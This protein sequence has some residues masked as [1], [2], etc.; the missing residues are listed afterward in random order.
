MKKRA[1]PAVLISA[2]ALLI[3][4]TAYANP[5]SGDDVRQFQTVEEMSEA[6]GLSGTVRTAGYAEAGDGGAMTYTVAAAQPQGAYGDIA[7]PL[8]DGSWAV[9]QGLDEQPDAPADDSA[10]E[11]ELARA[12]SFAAAGTDLIWDSSRITPLSGK[13]IHA[14]DTKPYAVTCSSFVNMVLMGWDYEHTTYVADENTRVGEGVDFGS[15]AQSGELSGAANLARWFHAHGRTWLDDGSSQYQPGDVL[16]FSQQSVSGDSSPTPSTEPNQFANIYHVA[17]YVGDGRIIHS[18]GPESGAGVVEEDFSASL[19]DDLSFVAR[20]YAVTTEETSPDESAGTGQEP[21]SE[22][23]SAVPGPAPTA[24]PS[25]TQATEPAGTDEA[26]PADPAGDDAE[27]PKPGSEEPASRPWGLPRTGGT[28]MSFVG[29]AM[30]AVGTAA[31][32]VTRRRRR[33]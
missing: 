18:Y 23:T 28:I 31:S 9:P 14:T 3:P 6:S 7:V 8:A 2:I 1:I 19:R 22:T 5:S 13:V 11:Q 15:A 17:L 12:Q 32:L 24:E 10:V 33:D 30:V 21:S 4:G 29:A 20:P 27:A 16:F 26:L 25:S